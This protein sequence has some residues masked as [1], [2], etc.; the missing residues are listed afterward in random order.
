MRQLLKRFLLALSLVGVMAGG[1]GAPSQAAVTYVE[2]T[3]PAAVL[4]DPLKVSL[5]D[6]Q[7]SEESISSLRNDPRTYVEAQL[8]LTYNNLT[9]GPLRVAVKLKGQWGSFRTIDEK[10]AF[11]VKVNEYVKGQTILGLKKL[12]LNNM[13]QDATA[14]HEAMSYRLFRAMGVA[15]PRVGY[16]SVEVND[17]PYGLYANIETVDKI[18]LARWFASTQHL[19]EGAYWTDVLPEHVG[20]YEVDEGDEAN[21]SDLQTLA[22]V[23]AG[24]FSAWYQAVQPYADLNQMTKMWAVEKFVGHWDG[25]S[26][27]IWNNYY[28]HSTTAGKFSMLP[29]GTDQTWDMEIP[30]VAGESNGRMFSY[31]FQTVECRGNYISALNTVQQSF[32]AGDYLTMFNSIT[33]AVDPYYVYSANSPGV[34]WITERRAITT[35]LLDSLKTPTRI[36]ALLNLYVP[37][38]PVLT[39]TNKGLVATLSWTEVGKPGFADTTEVQYSLNRGTTWFPVAVVDGLGTTANLA[40]NQTRMFRVRTVNS[41]GA[42]SWS[43]GKTVSTPAQPAVPKLSVKQQKGKSVFT[44]AG[45]TDVRVTGVKYE[46][47]Y[48]TNKVNWTTTPAFVEKT[49]SIAIPKGK[50][51]YFRIRLVSDFGTT[52]WS[53]TLLVRQM[54]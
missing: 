4:F 29:W 53:T 28:L 16:A 14:T 38:R 40:L 3:D 6:F 15:A 7:L 12:T 25:Y 52:A 24:D 51:W 45:P 34:D 10:A 1:L 54:V 9:I 42:G 11:K 43:L 26:S 31:C 41:A 48:S 21:R 44:W 17:V 46:I 37:G 19:Y 8:T 27:D 47:S 2:G 20:N 35:Y 22:N 33:A 23:N 13:V 32:I 5:I 49:K 36:N 18:M 39:V 30:F 50:T